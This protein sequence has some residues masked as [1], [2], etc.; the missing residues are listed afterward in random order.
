MASKSNATDTG[1]STADIAQEMASKRRE[2][3]ISEFF[4]KNR[5][6]LGFDN[7]RKAL[8]TTVK[9]AVDN[10]LDACEEAG[11]LPEI[12]VEIIEI[13]EDHFRIIVEDNGPGIVKKQIPHV[14]AKLLYGS[15]FHKLSQ[16]RGQQGIGISAAVM[17]AQLT[18]GRP[19]KITSRIGPK[20]DAHYYELHID[21]QKNEPKILQESVVEWASEHGVKVELDIEASY[22]K[23]DQS[24]DQYMKETAI[25]NPH[26]TL[27]Y[28]NP[29]AEQVIFTRVTDALPDKPKEIK[30]HPYGVEKYR[31]TH[32]PGFPD[33]RILQ[34]WPKHC[35][36]N[37]PEFQPYAKQQAP[38]YGQGAGGASYQ[39]H[40][41]NQNHRTSH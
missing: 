32:T 21:T 39:R 33:Q 17:Y 24:V 2:I 23:G 7:K 38:G 3:S 1:Q 30:P 6:L 9:E 29:K 11:I 35:K 4:A 41:E 26:V 16:S 13:S 8:L 40:K 20:T 14:F 28:T 22:Q 5:H 10:S 27:I 25:V 18:T 12:S 36:G 19:A 34:G 15:K 31:D 37:L